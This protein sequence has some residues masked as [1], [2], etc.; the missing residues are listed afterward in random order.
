MDRRD[1]MRRT[2]F[3]G[4]RRAR[5]ERQIHRGGGRDHHDLDAMI[6]GRPARQATA[7]KDSV[8]GAA[9]FMF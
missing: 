3:D 1:L 2:L 8:S 5:A 7:A 9:V 4:D 6:A